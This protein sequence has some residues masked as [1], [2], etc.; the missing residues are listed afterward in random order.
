MRINDLSG[1]TFKC[2]FVEELLQ[3]P[4]VIK[5]YECYLILSSYCGNNKKKKEEE[6]EGGG[7]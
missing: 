3:Y 7:R 1:K 4:T 6:V 5:L 2:R